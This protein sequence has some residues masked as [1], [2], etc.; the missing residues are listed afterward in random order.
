VNTCHTVHNVS[1]KTLV[2]MLQKPEIMLAYYL[3]EVVIAKHKFFTFSTYL[4]KVFILFPLH[5][6]KIQYCLININAK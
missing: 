4:L 6:S 5:W 1:F 2:M 3:Q